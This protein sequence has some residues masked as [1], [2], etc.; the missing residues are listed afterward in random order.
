MP[1]EVQ[2]AVLLNSGYEVLGRILAGDGKIKFTRAALDGGDIPD[3]V[4]IEDLTQPVD[5]ERDG[6]I[7]S[8]DNTGDGEATIVVQTS[9]IG[10]ETGFS[11]KGVMLFVEDPEESNVDVAYSYLPLQADPVW[12]R[13]EGDA[14]SKLVTFEIINVVSSASSVVAVISPDGLARAADLAAY[15]RRAAEMVSIPLSIPVSAWVEGESTIPRCAFYAD[16]EDSHISASHHPDVALDSISL[17]IASD[18]GLSTTAEII[19]SGKVRFY[20]Q[21][22]PK[23]GITGVCYL[24]AAGIDAE[25]AGEGS[26][27][28]KGHVNTPGVSGVELEK[29]DEKAEKAL[30]AVSEFAFV[31]NV[32][33]QNGT[34]IFNGNAQTPAWNGFDPKMLE[35]SGVTSGTD[36]GTYYAIFTPKGE[37]HW[38]GG[39][40]DPVEVPWSIQRASISTVPSQSGTLTYNGAA[41]TPSWLNFDN[42]MLTIGG[43]TSGTNAGTY[44]ATFTPKSNYRWSDGT[45]TAKSV[46]WSIGRASISAVPSQSGSLTY[47]GSA[48]SPSWSGYDSAK[49]TLGGTS[50]ATNA[51]SYTAT[52]TPTSNYKWAD[53]T[54]AEK[55]VN[56]SIS[57]AAGSLSLD[58]SSMTL[59]KAATSGQIAVT[60][61]GDGTISATSSNTNV[62][63]VSVSGNTV[64]VTGKTFGSVTITV[65]VA[66]GTNHNAPGNKTCSVTVNLFNATLN[67]NSWAAIKAASDADEGANYWAVG[68]TKTITI[69]GT[70]GNF[71]FSNL[72]VQAFILGFNHNSA[73]EGAHRIHFMIGKISGKDV[74]LCNSNYN[75]E[76]TSAGGFHM[77]TSRTNVGGWNATAMRKTLLGNSGTPSNPPAGSLMAALPSDLRAVMKSVTKYTDNTGNSSNTAAAVT[78]TTDYLSLVA[79]FEVHGSRSYANQYEKNSQLQYDYFKAGNSKVAYRHTATSS[80]VWWWSRSA[81]YANS[82]TF[83][84]VSAGGSPSYHIASWSAGVRPCFFV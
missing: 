44:T 24:L 73:K 53:G 50:S 16:L 25:E 27:E 20:A 12:I 74:A 41:Q 11:V 70:V 83:C 52:F 8:T 49:M 82:G 43:N 4:L 30:Q 57:K 81:Y 33:S 48:L 67:S 60:R 78:A 59:N 36:A 18:C 47:T 66:A 28:T 7:I 15:A 77:N 80:A 6:L 2:G 10:V 55:S 62:A 39:S 72:S 21:K 68:D 5:F 42:T 32:P 37:Y 26:A 19:E 58:K 13:P 75:N 56:W 34:L 45:T 46:T 79:E 84:Y 35:L 14:V 9:S 76:E 63:T 38:T 1:N 3:G 51:G 31:V 64:T 17:D 71:T 29:V 54:T 61:A 22:I 65:K 40:T 23:S 69:N